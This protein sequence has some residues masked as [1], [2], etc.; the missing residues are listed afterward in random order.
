MRTIPDNKVRTGTWRNGQ[1]VLDE[2]AD[3]PVGCKLQVTPISQP[4]NGPGLDGIDPARSR[5]LA[6]AQGS[7][8]AEKAH[9]VV[10]GLPSQCSVPPW[11]EA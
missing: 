3:W 11:G 7:Y 2:P 4:W 8:R 10:R 5:L 1:I 6:R 9:A